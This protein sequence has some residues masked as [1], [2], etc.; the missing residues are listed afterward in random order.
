MG[1]PR[2][3]RRGRP[4]PRGCSNLFLCKIFAENFMKMENFDREGACVSGAIPLD[5]KNI[6]HYSKRVRSCHLLC[7]RPGCHHGASKTHVRD[8][9]FKLI[10]MRASVIYQIPKFA[11]FIEFPLHLGKT[12]MIPFGTSY[13]TWN[14]L[15]GYTKLVI[16]S[17]L[18][19]FCKCEKL[20][21][22]RTEFQ[23]F[24]HNTIRS[25]GNKFNLTAQ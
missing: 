8:G 17:I 18:P 11:G 5:P 25:I 1:N 23:H 3:A 20:D 7:Q 10:R 4:L 2:F 24:V 9:I 16:M 13:G 15:Y 21:F 22:H 12:L 14:I 19:I 6:C